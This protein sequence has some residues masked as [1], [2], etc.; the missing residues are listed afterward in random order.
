[1]ETSTVQAL[2]LAIVS[3]TGLDKDALHIYVG[4][5]VFFTVAALF[6]RP[7]RSQVPWL[8]VLAVAIVGEFFDMRDDIASLGHWRWKASLHDIVNTQ[9]WPAVIMLLARF[10]GLFGRFNDRRI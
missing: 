9:F 4:L 8:V 7:L 1:M 6:K 3:A 5:V 10:S 2:K